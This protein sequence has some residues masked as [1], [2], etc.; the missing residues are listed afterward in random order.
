MRTRILLAFAFL[1]ASLSALATPPDACTVLSAQEVNSIAAGAVE[2]TQQRKT[3]NPSECAYVDKHRG[4]VLVVSIR[5]VQYAGENE[6]QYER[7][8]LEKIY[9]GKVKWLTGVGENGFWMPVNKVLMFR[10]KKTLVSVSF[11]RPSNQNEVDSSQV[12]R[13]IESRLP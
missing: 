13:L 6:L 8:N 2:K 4:A 1:A 9:R 7:E 3:G 12:A 5:E 10:K 11:A